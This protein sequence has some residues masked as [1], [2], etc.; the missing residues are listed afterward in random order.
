M[1]D[2]QPF[3]DKIK[4]FMGFI[5]GF[6]LFQIFF[7]TVL[8]PRK[9]ETPIPTTT[10]CKA[11]SLQSVIDSLQIDIKISEDGFDARESRYEDV[12]HEYE[13]GLSYLQ[14]YHPTAYK[15]FHR[16]I[17][18]KERYSHELERENKQRLNNF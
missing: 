13:I 16:I 7:W 6:I 10:E 18:M 2:T 3:G 1:A 9:N 12:I 4:P 17:G 15:D 14:D 5:I 8:H 11:D